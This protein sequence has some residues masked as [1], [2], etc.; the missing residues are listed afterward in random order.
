[1]S[2]NSSPH[3][4]RS[5]T[6]LILGPFL[7]GM[8]AGGCEIDLLYVH[9]LEIKPCLGCLACWVKTPG[10][11]VQQDDMADILTMMAGSDIVVYATPLYVDGM[12]A[13]MKNLLDRSI[14]LLQPWFVVHEDHCRH[15]RIEGYRD[16]K[17]VLVSVCGFTELDNF[18]P[19]VAHMA[20]ASRN[21]R[22]EFAGALLRPYA[23]S[24]PELAE[25]G[26]KVDGVYAAAREAGEQLV[27]DGR[28]QPKTLKRISR[29]LL[30]RDRYIQAVNHHFREAIRRYRRKA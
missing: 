11:C 13:T 25:S 22:R 6:D 7:D 18:D 19:L 15:D 26:I 27:R 12:N 30:P 3:V 24:L 28:M 17:V 8:G 9:K 29:E 16:G 23:N 14:P 21:M 5:A 10:R 1:M 20:A 4:E 2:F